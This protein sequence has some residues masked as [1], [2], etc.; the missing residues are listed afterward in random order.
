MNKLFTEKYYEDKEEQN[1]LASKP[2][3]SNSNQIRSK[4]KYLYFVYCKIIDE[5]LNQL[6]HILDFTFSKCT[7]I[8]SRQILINL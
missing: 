5:I 6:K 7:F 8:I 3:I 4:Q 1:I 2:K